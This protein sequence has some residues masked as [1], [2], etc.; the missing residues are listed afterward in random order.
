M[1]NITA[2]QNNVWKSSID[3]LITAIW[4]YT[5][6]S[7]VAN[8]IDT[9]SSVTSNLDI[10]DIMNGNVQ[11][12]DASDIAS[13][14]FGIFVII[15]YYLFFKALDTFSNHQANDTDKENVLK[16]KSGYLLLLIG[17]FIDIIPI[18]G[19]FIAFVLYIISYVKLI[20]GY[21]ALSKSYMLNDSCKQGFSTLKSCV[22][23][24]LIASVIGFIPIAGDIIE[25]L[26]N[27]I[28]FFIILTA[29]RNIAKN[30]PATQE[31]A[32]AYTTSNSSA[33]ISDNP[34]Y[35]IL[36]KQNNTAREYDAERLQEII[37]NPTMYKAELVEQCKKEVEI[38]KAAEAFVEEI[39]KYDD[40]KI[41]EI[42]QDNNQTY[43]DALVYC[44]TQVK[45]ERDLR[46]A[47]QAEEERKRLEE[48]AAQRAEQERIQREKEA[49]ERRLRQKESWDKNKKY[50]YASIV[51][52]IIII[53][54][55][56]LFSDGR[57]YSKGL[58]AFE[59]KKT[60]EAIK[61]LK[62]IGDGYKEN[63]SA[64]FM[65]YQLYL[66]QK[67]SASAASALTASVK[68]TTWSINPDAY[69]EYSSHLVDGSF[70][71]YIKTD[72]LSAAKF[73][74]TS[75]EYNFFAG[76]IY[77]KLGMHKKAHEI[78]A[79]AMNYNHPYIKHANGYLGIYNLFGLNSSSLEK[80]L[81]KAKELL[82]KAPDQ[83]PFLDYKILLNIAYSPRNYLDRFNTVKG[84]L[85]MKSQLLNVTDF[86]TIEKV[87][88]NI[89]KA[90]DRHHKGTDWS[91][92][93]T[94]DNKWR[95][96]NYYGDNNGQYTGE[97][98]EWGGGD[99]GAHGWGAFVGHNK[100]NEYFMY[101]EA[102]KYNR[103]DENGLRF[104][105]HTYPNSNRIDII[106][107]DSNGDSVRWDNSKPDNYK[108]SKL[109]I[110]LPFT[111]KF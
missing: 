96:Y 91:G 86:T 105:V 71:P 21:D 22:I 74:R 24:T 51:L 15:G 97:Y 20:G 36:D 75:P 23:W 59:N 38:R 39:S 102:G 57:Q 10:A 11:S 63:S 108:Y 64:K 65:L 26:I 37:S 66:K 14:T 110:K 111:A 8:I 81:E 78:F 77:F 98:G 84:M 100:E 43:S 58:K 82:G 95:Y 67:D 99:A 53:I 107:G 17:T 104:R 88:T 93:D 7:I 25:G 31:N 55:A 9:V 46:Y 16:V 60:E 85:C 44:C 3:S 69:K 94:F 68:D 49:Q 32:F 45:R 50:V 62:K 70:A 27:L 56:Y 2:G 106:I 79:Y 42:I 73:L 92:N 87:I 33:N 30:A 6:C 28:T 83:A 19:G 61:W 103:C 80:N 18:I 72:L 48:E 109:N 54:L 90:K 12:F 52:I 76:E 47:Q 5:L 4:I 29:W 41:N 40:I 13:A 101:V 89:F 35:S 1:E 34:S